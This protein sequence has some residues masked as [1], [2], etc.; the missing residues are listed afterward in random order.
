MDTDILVDNRIANGRR[1]AAE[2]VRDGLDVTA[3]G[4]IKPS[5]EDRWLLYIASKA[6][7]EKGPLPAYRAVHAALQRL[8][9]PSVS[10]MEVKLI[11]ADHPITKDM[12]EIQRCQPS[13][14]PTRFRGGQFGG[15]AVDDA[16]IYPSSA[17]TAATF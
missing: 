7:D 13:S 1:L 11:G 9:G 8:P 5:E 14:I 15:V 2:L 10:L 12:L 6:V 3:V 17:G 16:Y 4:W